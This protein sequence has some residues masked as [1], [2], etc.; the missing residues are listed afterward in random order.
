ML[1]HVG[2]D[3]SD[4]AR[5]RGFY[6]KALAP[7]GLKLLME[8]MP[9]IGGSGR[10]GIRLEIASDATRPGIRPRGVLDPAVPPNV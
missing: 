2:F 4:Y 9:S 8:P 10:T 7:L 3:V 5:S 6:E 1:D